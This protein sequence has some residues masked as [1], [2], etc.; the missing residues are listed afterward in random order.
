MPKSRKVARPP[1]EEKQTIQKTI[2]KKDKKSPLFVSRPKNFGIGND[3]QP[4]RDLTRFVK[5]PLY[6]RRQRHRKILSTRL[7]VP[8]PVQQF[9]TALEKNPASQ[10]FLLLNKIRPETHKDKQKRLKEEAKKSD[11]KE[12]SEAPI[13]VKYGLRHVTYLI[14]QKKAR[15]VII[16][17]D[18]DPI[19]LVVFLPTLCRKKGVP[20]CIVKS[21]SR[22]GEVV[23]KKTA[24][25]LAITKVR[26]EDEST[27][28][29][30]VKIARET[31]NDRY[32]VF[33]RTSGGNKLGLKYRQQ[34]AKRD[35][36]RKQED[37]KLEAVKA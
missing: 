14:E 30:L 24:A 4:K 22:L 37:K 34:K 27:L 33:M 32:P 19:E 21:K 16:A 26:S 9:K 25:V 29:D 35:K 36:R 12:G 28:A 10:L 13:V 15:L 2:N 23:H 7:V 20:Y 5:W 17:H 31:F 1:R 3:V 8:P 11:A 6:V 18:V